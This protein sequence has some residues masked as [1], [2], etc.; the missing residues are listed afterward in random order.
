[1]PDPDRRLEQRVAGQ[2]GQRRTC[3]SSARCDTS[4]SA[5]NRLRARCVKLD[6]SP[7]LRGVAAP[8]APV[9]GGLLADVFVQLIEGD[10]AVEVPRQVLGEQQRDVPLG[11][12]LRHPHIGQVVERVDHCDALGAN[13]G[14]QAGELGDPGGDRGA[15][16]GQIA[17][18]FVRPSSS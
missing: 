18:L 10:C 13:L 15:L 16:A 1:M 3:R 17:A 4:R 14:D 6:L 5:V 11:A 9:L 8:V 7:R 12:A 2:R